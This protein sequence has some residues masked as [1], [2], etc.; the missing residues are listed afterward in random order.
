MKG[1]MDNTREGYDETTTGAENKLKRQNGVRRESVAFIGEA[2]YNNQAG[3]TMSFEDV[4]IPMTSRAGDEL[5]HEDSEFA[6]GAKQ[7]LPS[8]ST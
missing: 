5:Q 6:S 7:P 2:T 8:Q 4:S 3:A 1:K